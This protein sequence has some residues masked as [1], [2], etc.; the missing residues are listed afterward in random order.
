MAASEAAVAAV[1]EALR[2]RPEGRAG[3]LTYVCAEH[4]TA[5]WDERGCSTARA[6]AQAAVD[7]DRASI[8]AQALRDYASEL[9]WK[10]PEKCPCANPESCCGSE[11]SCDAMQ[12][13]TH[14]VGAIN[15]RA[16]AD[17]I[18]GKP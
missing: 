5:D 8:Q 15:L 4:I 18:E 16:R 12:P 13:V 14:I 9:D 10:R 1:M 11:Q 6:T 2:C 17:R 3:D 7:A